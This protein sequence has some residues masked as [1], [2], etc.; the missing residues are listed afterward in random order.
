[1]SNPA[2]RRFP[3]TRNGP[4][5]GASPGSSPIPM[6]RIPSVPMHRT[7]VPMTPR[8]AGHPE[9]PPP[10][11]PAEPIEEDESR[12]RDMTRQERWHRSQCRLTSTPLTR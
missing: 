8:R 4:I 1:M 11:P 3:K 12:Q 5:S 2:A 6:R 9:A 10:T 7:S